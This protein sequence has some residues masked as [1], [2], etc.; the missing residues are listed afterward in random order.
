MKSTEKRHKP[1]N[2]HCIQKCERV[3]EKGN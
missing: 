2:D 3:S 1:R